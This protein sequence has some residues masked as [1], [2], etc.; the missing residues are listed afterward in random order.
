MCFHSVGVTVGLSC[1]S[2]QECIIRTIDMIGKALHPLRLGNAYILKERDELV[3]GM[4]TYVTDG[5]LGL[6]VFAINALSTLAYVFEGNCSHWRDK[7][8]AHWPLI[9]TLSLYPVQ[10]CSFGSPAKN[11]LHF[12]F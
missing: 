1:L 7:S 2:V 3:K 12:Y 8:L 9:L 11:S 5:T 4:L 6:K 10:R